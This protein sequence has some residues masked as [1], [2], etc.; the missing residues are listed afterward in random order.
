[1]SCVEVCRREA[2]AGQGQVADGGELVKV[3]VAVAGFL[4]GEL[5]APQL[6]VL[7]LQLDLV[8]LE[9]VQDFLAGPCL[10]TGLWGAGKL[11]L[12]L[13]PQL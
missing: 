1:M 10:C 2:L 3:H 12:R 13:G 4:Q 8:H 5:S 11:R 6:I 7:H 9:L